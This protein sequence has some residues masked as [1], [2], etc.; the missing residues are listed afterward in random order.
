MKLLIIF[1]CLLRFWR[2]NHAYRKPTMQY[3]RAM[4]WVPLPRSLGT[5]QIP[6]YQI[7]FFHYFLLEITRDLSA[8]KFICRKSWKGCCAAQAGNNS[9]LTNG[10]V[11]IDPVILWNYDGCLRCR[12]G[13]GFRIEGMHT[14]QRHQEES[15]QVGRVHP[16]SPFQWLYNFNRRNLSPLQAVPPLLLPQPQVFSFFTFCPMCNWYKYTYNV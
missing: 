2:W 8:L 3:L 15:Q 16:P 5:C 1:T 4:S 12:F 11:S 10:D 13:T 7:F 14:E 9:N 6:F